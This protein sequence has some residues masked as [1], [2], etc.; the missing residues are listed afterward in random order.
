MSDGGELWTVRRL[1]TTTK[2]FFE[3]KGIGDEARLD[4]E[5]LLAEVIGVGRLTLYTD[6]DRPVLG[7]ELD[8]FRE[9]VR[10]RSKRE[11]TA[12]VLGR[13]GF[14][15]LQFVID[16]RALVPRRETEMLAEHCWKSI[17]DDRGVVL[18][19]CTGSGVIA[20]SVAHYAVGAEIVATDISK[21][22]L[23]LAVSNAEELGVD[24]RV[25]FLQGDL[26]DALEGTDSGA[27]YDVIVANPPY[28]RD[29]DWDGLEPEITAFEPREA[30]T[31]GEDGL[32]VI[33]RI[34]QGA[35]ERLAGG[36]GL[37]LEIGH[38]QAAAVGGLCREAGLGEVEVVEDYGGIE[39]IVV[40]RLE[41]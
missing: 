17:G 26:Y 37:M 9:M 33:R 22:A 16:A 23:E 6:H 2:E 36:G 19:L 18:E 4:A 21:G 31:A 27:R 3:S 20:C 1:L 11:P 29:D 12:Y 15:S 39:R 38:G 34:V 10:R 32:E 13:T 28:V 8:R 30:L 24:D 41:K 7:A 5:L 35:S 14:C 25:T 40:A